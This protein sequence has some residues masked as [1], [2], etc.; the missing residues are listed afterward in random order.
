MKRLEVARAISH[1][2]PIE[3]IAH[4][5]GYTAAPL[6]HPPRLA[7]KQ[8]RADNK[9]AARTGSRTAW[10][11]NLEAANRRCPELKGGIL[12]SRRQPDSGARRGSRAP[13]SCGA[14][15]A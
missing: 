1:F 11:S 8:R 12:R 6:C 7:D 15:P 9:N 13:W 5:A 10:I 14:G 4:R 3:T 2:S